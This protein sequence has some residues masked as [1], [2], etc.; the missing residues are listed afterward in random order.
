MR[1]LLGF[2]MAAVAQANA[3]SCVGKVLDTAAYITASGMQLAVVADKCKGGDTDACEGQVVSFS[4]TFSKAID[5]LQQAV[6]LCGGDKSACGYS[7]TQVYEEAT[8][9]VSAVD[10]LR[11]HGG[12][13]GRNMQVLADE[14]TI[15]G[16]AITRSAKT[17]AADPDSVNENAGYCMS[18]A[19]ESATQ[20]AAAGIA[21]DKTR[22]ECGPGEAVTSVCRMDQA[23]VMNAISKAA[24]RAVSA[25]Q[26][27]GSDGLLACGMDISTT[28]AKLAEATGFSIQTKDN[29]KGGVVTSGGLA[30]LDSVGEAIGAASESIGSATTNCK[31]DA[32]SP[33]VNAGH[34]VADSI[35]A[36]AYVASASMGIAVAVKDCAHCETTDVAGIAQCV[37]D[38]T[39]T[40]QNYAKTA[41]EIIWATADCAKDEAI[42][43][44]CA[45]NVGKAI[46]SIAAATAASAHIARFVMAENWASSQGEF[47]SLGDALDAWGHQ[48]VVQL[49][50]VCR[51]HQ[52][53]LQ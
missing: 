29:W 16:S 4:A 52:R 41:N 34:C 23:F 22:K 47:Q 42:N 7:I 24:E 37:T 39:Y 40:I 12:V 18:K 13:T 36:A 32:P 25:S 45:T 27:C 9:L 28:S 14:F 21:W 19:M 44:V 8:N 26:D 53:R 5:I 11:A 2:S 46:E 20:V 17:C 43:T 1:L 10:A 51:F 49:P 35:T 33:E 6:S 30:N 38:V 31:K 50:H 48:S 15:A 3:G